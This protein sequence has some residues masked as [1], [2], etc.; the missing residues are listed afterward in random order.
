MSTLFDTLRVTKDLQSSGFDAGHNNDIVAAIER[1]FDTQQATKD[2]QSSGFD[3]R[4][5][6]GIVAA[7]ED[8]QIRATEAKAD[9]HSGADKF[10]Y[11][12][13][14]LMF[15]ASLGLLALLIL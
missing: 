4:Q 13:W 11:V 6:E 3:A 14:A 15:V 1:C 8:Y 5:A 2:L 12:S 7:I 9:W 10:F